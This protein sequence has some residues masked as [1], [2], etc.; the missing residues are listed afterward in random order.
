MS[1]FEERVSA[2]KETAIKAVASRDLTRTEVVELLASKRLG[3]DVVDAAVAELEELG[4]VD[5][6]RVAEAY[7]RSQATGGPVSRVMIE[8]AL[9]ERG[10]E[11][12]LV[13]SVLHEQMQGREEDMEALELARIRVRTSPA[14]LSPEAIKRRA[15]AYLA[16]R[17]FDEETAR[18]AVETAA[19]EYLGRP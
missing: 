19:E 13:A 8:A 10:V 5:D 16:R 9:I 2:A 6:R 4:I 18:Q 15:F 7:V 17:G 12:G 14:K 11:P 3:T 1:T